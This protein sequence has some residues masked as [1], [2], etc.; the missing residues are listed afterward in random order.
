MAATPPWY[1]DI[2]MAEFSERLR[3]LRSARNI[4]Q[5]RLAEL[6]GISPRS[7]NRW[8]RGGN[9]PH[10]DMLI[11]IAD[12]L[13]VSLDELVGRTKPSSDIAIH[14]HEL[15]TLCQQA[16]KLPDEDQKAL[17]QIMDGLV[18]KAQLNE[19]LRGKAK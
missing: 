8:E 13:Q 19:V 14:N 7:Y 6:L 3:L 16:N 18:K 4:K 12:I 11:K 9:L 2:N 10:L 15:H 17:I 1:A 5:S